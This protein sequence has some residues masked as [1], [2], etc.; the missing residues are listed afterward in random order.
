V[1]SLLKVL[2]ESAG[3]I[4]TAVLTTA[5]IAL[6]TYLWR[7]GSWT[8]EHRRARLFEEQGDK[9]VS[10]GLFSLAIEQFKA[11]N[12]IWE[13]EVN[14][15]KMLSLYRK[16]GRA[17]GKLGESEQA[18]EALTHCEA[19]WEALKKDVKMYDIYFEKAQIYSVKRNW[20]RA[21]QYIHLTIEML[22]T[23][24]S[25]RLPIA[26]SLAA[27]IAKEQGRPEEAET[28]YVE[29][30]H[31]LDD[32][33]DTLGLASVYYELGD[34]K[35]AQHHQELAI[36]YYGKSAEA[37]ETLGSGRADEIRAKVTAF[38]TP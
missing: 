12:K 6:F 7:A 4:I 19:L 24:Q 33:G 14:Q 8:R 5:F 22:R 25:P 17:Y 37:Y 16:I 1:D 30:L 15:A 34:L 23:V 10:T 2:D 21:S 9:F 11:A 36:E 29:A 35:Y 18:L 26:L 28:N 31:L 13:V 3:K 27:R 38:A 32:I 20:E